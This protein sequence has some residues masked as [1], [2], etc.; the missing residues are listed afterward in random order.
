VAAIE[1]EYS[2][3]KCPDKSTVFVNTL[4]L[5]L[6]FP[7][8][9]LGESRMEGSEDRGVHGTDLRAREGAILSI[10]NSPSGSSSPD[11][12]RLKSMTGGSRQQYSHC[13]LSVRRV[14]RK[15]RIGISCPSRRCDGA[16]LTSHRKLSSLPIFLYRSESLLW[17]IRYLRSCETVEGRELRS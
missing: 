9:S 6:R 7:G 10:R 8:S 14:R 3:S 11:W 2:M 5:K 1:R 4:N 17:C 13:A 15:Q 16:T 12:K